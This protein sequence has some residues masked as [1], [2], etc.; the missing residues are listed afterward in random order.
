M[1]IM[2]EFS[3]RQVDGFIIAAAEL[4]DEAVMRVL[5]SGTPV[6]LYHRHAGDSIRCN[7]IGCDEQKAVALALEH[8]ETL[9][10]RKVAFISGSKRF[11]TGLERVKAFMDLRSRYSLDGNSNFIKEGGYDMART[12]RAV[13]ELMSMQSR[14]T[15]IFAANDFMALQVLDKLMEMGFSVPQDV[16]VI[17]LDNIPI[18][19]HHRISL[20]T[21]DIKITSGA[22]QA[23]LSLINLMQGVS[24]NH[25]PLR[26]LQEPTLV[27]RGSTARL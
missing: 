1:R 5:D 27:A 4:K 26:V 24:A 10:H 25:E 17:G 3:K 16:S 9:G 2:E 14:P 6:I 18:A 12:S 21:V 20:S 8:L 11:S 19:E 22:K 15:A 23:I 7:F 13:Q